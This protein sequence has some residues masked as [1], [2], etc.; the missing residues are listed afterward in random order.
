[1]TVDRVMEVGGCNECPFLRWGTE[2]GYMCKLESRAEF[3][4]REPPKPNKKG[5][6]CPLLSMSVRVCRS[7]LQGAA[8]RAKAAAEKGE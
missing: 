8:Q 7:Q 6:P 2:I 1:M 3:T 4:R 5:K